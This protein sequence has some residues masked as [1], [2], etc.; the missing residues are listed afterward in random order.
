[1]SSSSRIIRCSISNRTWM[2]KLKIYNKMIPLLDVMLFINL[3]TFAQASNKIE[4]HLAFT[5]FNINTGQFCVMLID[6]PILNIQILQLKLSGFFAILLNFIIHHFVYCSV[7]WKWKILSL[8]CLCIM[9][10]I[11]LQ[12]FIVQLC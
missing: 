12:Y 3:I 6:G 7:T 10:C 1:M 9:F 4:W 5:P 2:K 11:F 8:E